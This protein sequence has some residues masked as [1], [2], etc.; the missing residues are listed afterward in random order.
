MILVKN[1]TKNK[2]NQKYLNKIADETLK[3][4]KFKKPVE[5][6]LVIT[7]EKRIRSLNKKYRKIDKIT[8]VL[9]FGND[10]TSKIIKNKSVKFISPPD[11]ILHLGE[12]FV[13]YP[14]AAKQAK[15]K[16]HSVREEIIVLLIHGIL[17]L[18]GYNHKVNYENSEMKIKEEEILENLKVKKF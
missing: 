12:I 6:S 13:C 16:N 11:N 1:F 17:H 5:I 8:D 18:L 14:Q 9:S 10:A 4:A 15:Q 7:G 3:V 2:F